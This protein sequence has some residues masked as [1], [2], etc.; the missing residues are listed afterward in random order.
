[1]NDLV[2]TLAA[3]MLQYHLIYILLYAESHLQDPSQSLQV[4]MLTSRCSVHAK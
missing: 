2:P 3:A 1:M 4:G